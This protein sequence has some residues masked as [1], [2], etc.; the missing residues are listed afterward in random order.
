MSCI[1]NDIDFVYSV[2]CIVDW[3]LHAVAKTP[4]N[5]AR[6]DKKSQKKETE[7]KS[8]KNRGVTKNHARSDSRVRSDSQ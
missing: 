2:I 3:N 4:K 7:E 1:F 8:Q 6:S 5:H